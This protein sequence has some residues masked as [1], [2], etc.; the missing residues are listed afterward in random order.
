VRY[1]RPFD[2]WRARICSCPPKFNLNVYTGCGHG[3]VYCYASSFIK[4]FYNPRVKRNFLRVVEED[5][6]KI[7]ERITIILSTSSDPYQP[8]ERDLLYTRNFL[9]LVVK[10]FYDKVNLMVVTKSSLVK[11]DLDILVDL[12]VVISLTI[13]SKSV[14]RKLEPFTP[15]YHEMK[16]VAIT[17]REHCIPLVIRI[18]PVIPFV[19]EREALDIFEE[20]L[21]L[22][23]HFVVSTYKAKPDS[24]KRLVRTFPEYSEKLIEL[25]YGGER[26]HGAYYLPKE[27]RLRVLKPF[28][29]IAIKRG[30][31]L[32][33]C[34]EALKVDYL[35]KSCDG[36]H[37][38]CS[39]QV[40]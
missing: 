22:A 32:A 21:D 28:F 31:S 14:K 17:L 8:L 20:L 24:L 39:S 30:K 1:I 15:S 18:D 12:P 16:E 6:R 4:D 27:E 2:P 13:T 19:N 9:E 7:D 5:L 38:F 37:L 23:D 33:T 11:R 36:T 40:H 29:D 3:C 10:F 35:S 34:R 26:I 25:Y